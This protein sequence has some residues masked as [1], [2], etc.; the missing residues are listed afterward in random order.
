M[1]S[2]SVGLILRFFAFAM[3]APGERLELAHQ[4]CIPMG[5]YVNWGA[6][7]LANSGVASTEGM[8][9]RRNAVMLLILCLVRYFNSHKRRGVPVESDLLSAFVNLR[10]P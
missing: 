10:L 8:D 3:I 9:A 4:D 5:F 6:S 1:S 7:D 2:A